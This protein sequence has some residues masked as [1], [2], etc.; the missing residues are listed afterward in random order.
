MLSPLIR[1]IASIDRLSLSTSVALNHLSTVY[2]M[3]SR[4]CSNGG[5]PPKLLG[6]LQNKNWP[7]ISS[8]RSRKPNHLNGGLDLTK[9]D[10]QKWKHCI[11][12]SLGQMS[13][14]LNILQWKW[15]DGWAAV[16]SPTK[17]TNR[18]EHTPLSRYIETPR[19]G[20]IWSVLN[21]A[22]VGYHIALNAHCG[23]ICR[24]IAVVAT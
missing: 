5:H 10:K 14:N 7:P 13:N 21:A 4:R 19:N 24:V 12:I 8:L 2:K 11:N 20:S 15:T 3:T 18:W 6:H 22:A 17:Q 1:R 9:S 23:L 16:R